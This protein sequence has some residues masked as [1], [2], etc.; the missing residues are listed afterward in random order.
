M[1]PAIPRRR[2]RIHGKGRL[3]GAAPG[4]VTVSGVPAAR[5]VV[6]VERASQVIVGRI[7]SAPDGTYAFSHLDPALKFTVY[8][9]DRHGVHNAVIVDNVSPALMPEFEP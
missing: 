2:D 8:A 6:I 1:A 5:D 7:L 4:I 3:A 9:W